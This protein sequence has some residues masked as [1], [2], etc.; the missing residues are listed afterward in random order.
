MKGPGVVRRIAVSERADDDQQAFHF[1][2]RSGFADGRQVAA[3]PG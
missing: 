3:E 2:Q 1:L